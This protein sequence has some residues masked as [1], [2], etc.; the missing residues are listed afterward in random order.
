M[1]RS[2]L[3]ST[4]APSNPLSACTSASRASTSRWLVGSSRISRCGAS[5]VISANAS[6][7]FSPPDSF[8]TWVVALLPEK[9][10]RP[11]WRA[12][13]G[14]RLALHHARRLRERRVA[15]VEFLD[16][17]PACKLADAHL[18]RCRHR[19]RHRTELRREQPRERRLAIAV[20]SEQRD[21]I[22]GIDTQVQP[23]QHRT[24]RQ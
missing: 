19:A 1:W 20:A 22:V 2:W 21:A 11:S 7:A 3:T 14:L 23:L 10:K 15:A 18:A 4:T 17:V 13:R 24:V 5:R 9:P 6:R 16:L 12:D 8:A